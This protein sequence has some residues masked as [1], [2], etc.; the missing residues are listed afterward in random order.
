MKG[1]KIGASHDHGRRAGPRRLQRRGTD[2]DRLRGVFGCKTPWDAGVGG[3]V[4]KKGAWWGTGTKLFVSQRRQIRDITKTAWPWGYQ[5]GWEGQEQRGFGKN[6]NGNSGVWVHREGGGQV[7]HVDGV[8]TRLLWWGSR[9]AKE[10]GSILTG[11]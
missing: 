9:G 4:M 7:K 11:D 3:A 1:K 5:G 10:R 6:C 8:P 2:I